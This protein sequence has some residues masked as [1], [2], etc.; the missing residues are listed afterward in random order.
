MLAILGSKLYLLQILFIAA[1]KS[2]AL[3]WSQKEWQ[4]NNGKSGNYKNNIQKKIT[5][6][7]RL[8]Q[9]TNCEHGDSVG[10]EMVS[11]Q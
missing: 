11:D 2:S 10:L 7:L 4:L 3:R 6:R 5:F 1:K 9:D 8:K